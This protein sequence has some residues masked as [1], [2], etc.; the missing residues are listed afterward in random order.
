MKKAGIIL[1]VLVLTFS[2]WY[3]FKQSTPVKLKFV[4][5]I[6]VSQLLPGKN[7]SKYVS[8]KVSQ[9]ETALDLL[10]KNAQVQSKGEGVNAYVDEIN[11]VTAQDS[12]KE[13]WALYINGKLA[14]VGAGSYY[15]KDSDKIEWEIDNY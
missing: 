8:Y 4:K 1:A 6:S 7:Q 5:Q 2:G 13:Y 9:G 11:G 3:I 12:K 15:L 10:K 14:N